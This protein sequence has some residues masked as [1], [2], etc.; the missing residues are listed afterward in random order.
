MERRDL[1]ATTNLPPA[2]LWTIRAG[3]AVDAAGALYIT[4]TGRIRKVSN[5]VITTVAGYGSSGSSGGDNGPAGFAQFQFPSGLALDSSGN[6]Y[7]TDETR[8]RKVSDGVITTVAGNG[9]NGFSGDDG[10]A[11]SAEFSALYGGSTIAVDSE[12]DLY[13]ADAMNNRVRKV[14]KGV[15]TTVAGGGGDY[16]G[17]NGPATSALLTLP[18]SVTVDSAGNLYIIENSGNRV[19][20]VSNGVIT[21]IA[22]NPGGV[23]LGDGGPATSAQFKAC[24]HRSGPKRK[25]LSHRRS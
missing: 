23:P 15:I 16:P 8:I 9:T 22:N 14:S 20:K 4:E 5:G 3:L 19:R 10:P 24:R 18:S 7:I 11:T 25:G 6:L 2:R 13:I 1:S 21:T 12:G 17:D